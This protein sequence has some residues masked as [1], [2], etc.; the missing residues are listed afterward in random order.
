MP[1]TVFDMIHATWPKLEMRVVV[2]DRQ[3]AKVIA[4]QQMDTRLL[5]SPLLVSL[6]YVVYFRGYNE[7]CHSDWPRLSQALAAGGNVRS[8]RLQSLQ[9]QNLRLVPETGPET[10]PRLNLTSGLRLPHLEEITFQLLEHW[11][12]ST[13]LWDTDHC[14]MFRDS[15]DCSRLRKLDFGTDNP[16]AFFT[17]FT[18]LC[19]KLK[20][21]SFGAAQGAM[22]PAMRFIESVDALEHLDV[23]RAQ[24]GIDDLWPAIEKHKDILKTLILG[25]ALGRYCSPMYMDLSRLEVISLTFPKLE[26]LGWDAPCETNVSLSHSN[27][28]TGALTVLSRLMR[29]IWSFY[30]A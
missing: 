24:L 23:S 10:L 16:T 17:Y 30:R 6:T 18:G 15:I 11:G 12:A 3:N 9:V 21:L 20:A 2:V 13:Y 22:E 29:N 19:P 7:S 4:H 28:I 14:R 26:R 8:L 25:P 27:N 1:R 5:S